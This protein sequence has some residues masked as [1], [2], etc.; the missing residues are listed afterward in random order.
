MPQLWIVAGPNGA[1]KTTL[2]SHRLARRIPVVNPDVIAQELPRVGGRLD[3]RRAGEIAIE[4]RNG[5]LT[6]GTDFAIETTLS[7]AS[8][9]RFLRTAKQVGYKVT[10]VYVGLTS[11]DLS[12]R[13]VLHRVAD[14]GHAVPVSAL[15]RRYPDIMSK[16]AQAVL[17]ADRSYVFDNSGRRRRLLV[18]RD[19]GRTR[20]VAADLPEWVV[21]S[22]AALLGLR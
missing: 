12:I 22:L 13:R 7:G 2:V 18:I 1:G 9:L 5:L 3:E 21:K 10:L 11:V 19:R 14:G 17:L 6:Q 15:E 4:R 16:L 8:A 20:Y